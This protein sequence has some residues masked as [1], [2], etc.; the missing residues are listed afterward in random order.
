M[1]KDAI[2]KR[3]IES[4]PARFEVAEGDIQMNCVLLDLDESSSLPNSP[5]APARSIARLRFRLDS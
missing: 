2:I 1:E 3:F 5:R 4:L